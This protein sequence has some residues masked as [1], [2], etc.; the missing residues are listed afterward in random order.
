VNSEDD[1]DD[2]VARLESIEIKKEAA[3]VPAKTAPTPAQA[4]APAAGA[5]KVS[6]AHKRKVRL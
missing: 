5:K 4:P 1:D 2:L 3:A 6:R